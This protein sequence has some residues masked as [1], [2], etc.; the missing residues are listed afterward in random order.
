MKK[1]ITIALLIVIAMGMGLAMA[2]ETNVGGHLKLTVYD[3]PSGEH[4]GVQSSN[5][6]GFSF[7]GLYLYFQKELTD[8]VSIDL[9]PHWSASTGATP[10]FGNEIA[11]KTPAGDID[12]HFHGFV[13]AVVK[14][15][16]PGEWE[17]AFGI[18]K[19]RF[20]WDYGAELFWEDQAD[21]GKFTANNFLGASHDGGFELYKNFELGDISMPLYLYLLN[22]GHEFSDN[23]NGPSV[24]ASV[25]PEMGAF[26]LKASL[27]MGKYDDEA[28]NSF[29]KYLVGAMFEKG[30]FSVRGEY[31]AGKWTK[32]IG[33]MTDAEPKGF[34]FKVYYRVNDWLKTFF[35]YDYVDNNYAGFFFTAP[36]SE[37]YKTMTPGLVI[38]L[39]G[40]SMLQIAYN[41]A[42]WEQKEKFGVPG[43]LDQIEF[44][45]AKITWRT[46][47]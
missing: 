6:V 25:E 30:P 10:S 3:R 23:N 12:P 5:Y 18:P 11:K 38:N 34:Y 41:M 24:M 26:K 36:G 43:Q 47:F 33:G 37:V 20:S 42:D 2:Q 22:G 17:M 14:V 44:N 46:T 32:S 16:L 13:K 8:K 15:M 9:Q 39:G 40:G 31:A 4:N 45:R 21:A 28:E 35:H 29:M 7:I 19:P 27:N 1:I